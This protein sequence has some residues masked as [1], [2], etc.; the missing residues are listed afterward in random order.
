MQEETNALGPPPE[1]PRL[2]P[3]VPGEPPVAPVPGAPPVAPV[4]GEPPDPPVP[5]E[6]PVASVSPSESSTL[7]PQPSTV[8]AAASNI[9]DMGFMR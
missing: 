7:P 5:A 9:Q 1:P 2:V 6:P 3:P 4:P 8:A